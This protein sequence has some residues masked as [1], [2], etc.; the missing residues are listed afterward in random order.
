MYCA[1]TSSS[2]SSFSSSPPCVKLWFWSIMPC[3]VSQ[4]SPWPSILRAGSP[5]E[6][7]WLNPHEV[8]PEVTRSHLSCFFFGFG[9][10]AATVHELASNIQR[11]YPKLRPQDLKNEAPNHLFRF[12]KPLWFLSFWD[13][14]CN[15]DICSLFRSSWC[16]GGVL[17]FPVALICFPE[18]FWGRNACSSIQVAIG[19]NI[20]ALHVSGVQNLLLV[21]IIEIIQTTSLE[22]IHSMTGIPINQPV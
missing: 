5:L 21:D 4:V 12:L 22:I 14:N 13:E 2:S 7:G 11:L 17:L 6:V 3:L 19:Q 15:Y 16:A 20:N 8:C 10:V 18:E 1:W 9:V